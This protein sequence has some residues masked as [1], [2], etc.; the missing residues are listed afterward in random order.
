MEEKRSS[1]VVVQRRPW[2][3]SFWSAPACLC[4][5][6]IE[7]YKIGGVDDV[8]LCHDIFRWACVCL[9][10]VVLTCFDIGD[11]FWSSRF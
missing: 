3:V 2:C 11:V 6:V 9:K 10:F 7:C 4:M 5:S 8:W 1:A